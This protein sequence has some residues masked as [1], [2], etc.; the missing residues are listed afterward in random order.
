[1]SEICLS[2]LTT[3][4][5]AA[6]R[7]SSIRDRIVLA[8]VL[9]ALIRASEV[10]A[11]DQAF[12]A[13]PAPK[14]DANRLRSNAPVSVLV[15]PAPELMTQA[16]SVERQEFSATEFRPRKHNLLDPEPNLDVAHG[17]PMLEDTTVWQ[18]LSDYR[19]H[20]RLRLLTL[21]ETSG[22]SV[23]LQSGRHGEPSVQWTSRFMN[24]GGPTRGL[25]DRLF[26]VPAG[27]AGN[28]LRNLGRSNS[29]QTA[30]KPVGSV[31]STISQK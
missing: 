4:P 22:S 7:C 21:W 25:F 6:A 13:E 31:P 15:L 27:G 8:L 26:S 3:P 20:D 24:H 14:P 11:S 16:P 12:T 9:Y 1:M 23:S 5:E 2:A 18:R 28:S 29:T 10:M 17:A 30:N 19:S